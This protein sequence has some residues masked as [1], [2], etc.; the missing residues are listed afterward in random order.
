MAADT[1]ALSSV[2]GTHV[3]HD[4]Q[5]GRQILRLVAVFVAVGYLAYAVMTAPLLVESLPYM[6]PWW[7]VLAIVLIFGTG[8]M[9]GPVGWWGDPRTTRFVAAS[10]AIGFIV[11]AALWWPAWNGEQ[12]DNV[13]GIWFSQFPGLAAIAAA[14]AFRPA[15]ALGHLAVAI[16]MTLSIGQVVRPSQ[17]NGPLV[18][19]IVWAYA[20]SLIFVAAAVMAIRTAA[21][22]DRTHAQAFAATADAAALNARTAERNRF[23]ALTHDNVM[24][25]LLSAARQGASPEL[26]A[27]ARAAIAAVER[28]AAGNGNAVVT[29]DVAVGQIR[30]AV[31]LVEP[32]VP[33]ALRE[34]DPSATYPGEAITA[35]A[36]AAA[37]AVRNSLRHAGPDVAV[38]VTV[39]ARAGALDVDVADDGRGF[40]PA[41]VPPARMG[42]A[43]SILGRMERVAGGVAEIDSRIGVGTRVHLGWAG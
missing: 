35:M 3:A 42:M 41:D 17:Y 5:A 36:A 13:R 31:G 14:M 12:I 24:S 26:A 9:L 20:F 1:A 10:A 7:S 23:D 21:L 32:A 19:D 30:A 6:A 4:D 16:A 38:S 2:G 22:L 8:L 43:V 34:S 40:D 18:A 15:V 25:T 37:E 28:A 29:A 33:V 39:R 11:A 27:E